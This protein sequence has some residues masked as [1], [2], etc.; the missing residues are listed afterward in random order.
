MADDAQP[1]EQERSLEAPDPTLRTMEALR[2]DIKAATDVLSERIVGIEGV[3]ELKELHRQELTLLNA[4]IQRLNFALRDTAADKL[5]AQAQKEISAALQAQK[6]MA[7]MTNT[8]MTTL[9]DKMNESSTK[10]IDVVVGKVDE[11]RGRMD[12]G[13][14][15]D[16]GRFDSRLERRADNGMY[17]MAAGLLVAAAVALPQL[18]G[19]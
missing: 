3:S 17:I 6:E 4:E 8:F 1:F 14:G 7:G 9:V 18:L 12:R 15:S 11:L 13:E 2:R 16:I 19:G 5:A 10:L